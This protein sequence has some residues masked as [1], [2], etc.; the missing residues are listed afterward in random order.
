MEIVNENLYDLDKIFGLSKDIAYILRLI[1]G[2]SPINQHELKDEYE[3]HFNRTISKPGFHKKCKILLEKGLI[4]EEKLSISKEY[5][6]NESKFENFREKTLALEFLFIN[7]LI[8]NIPRIQRNNEY[9]LDKDFLRDEEE[10]YN[11]KQWAEAIDVLKNK[12]KGKKL[13]YLQESKL[14]RLMGW[15][16]Y[17]LGLKKIENP[18]E[19]GEKARKSFIKVLRIGY[20]K[21]V[22]SALSGLPL[23]YFY[24]IK[25]S[26]K[27][28]KTM[29]KAVD[30]E[31]V[32]SI[33]NTQGL[34][35]R[36]EGLILDALSIFSESSNIAM[37]ENDFRTSGN[38][39]NN[40]ARTLMKLLP[41]IE[42]KKELKK[43]IRKLFNKALN[44]YKK[45]EEITGESAK[46]HIVDVYRKIDEV[47]TLC[48]NLG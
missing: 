6:L 39:L 18:K 1:S 36:E 23:V 37:K 32:G 45:Y 34:L 35:K 16:Y 10:L 19:M 30:K 40:K 24:L 8:S 9:Q 4:K 47:E 17:Y 29:E 14:Q 31:E 21:D 38:A 5:S 33:L 12:Y 22:I 13:N 44:D 25:D 2:L 15:C 42:S 41:L 7:N 28:F 27:A 11:S 46:F 26:K 3:R 43:D 20:Q 48:N